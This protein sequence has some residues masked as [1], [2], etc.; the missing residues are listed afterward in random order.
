MRG[1]PLTRCQF[2][3]PFADLHA[4]FG[5]STSTLLE[6]FCL[7]G[8]LEKKADNYV[9]LLQAVSFAET[10]QR[11]LGTADIGFHASSGLRF[12]HLSAVV[13][14]AIRMSPTLFV[15]LQQACR[16]ATLEDN[17]LR[18]WLEQHPDHVRICSKLVGTEGVPNL[19][20]SQW[21]QNV[22]PI[23]IVREFAGPAWL[24][25]VVAFEARYSP[26]PQTQALWPRTV[27]L[28]GQP[29]SW[30]EVPIELMSLRPLTP[31]VLPPLSAESAEAGEGGIICSLQLML[32]S[33]LGDRVPTVAEAA[34]MART[35]TRTLQRKLAEVGLSYSALIEEARFRKAAELLRNSSERVIDIAFALGY[36]DPAHFTRAFRRM[37]GT[38]PRVYRKLLQPIAG[39][40]W[41]YGDALPHN[42]MV[43]TPSR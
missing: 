5:I 30:I 23:H 17:V 35:S 6:K 39:M 24:P 26:S 36:S 34:E 9:P 11:S 4:E 7:P 12:D 13:K 41:M 20:H 16:L 3:I 22:L 25:G 32:P 27:F 28:S 40:T 38:T 8:S 19:E 14:S 10:A 43:P 21:L 42:G 18:M 15:G 31:A 37:S 33:Y 1:I 29:A 2:L